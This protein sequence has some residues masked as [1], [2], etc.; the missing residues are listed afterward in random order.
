MVVQRLRRVPPR[1]WRLRLKGPK[2]VA[3]PGALLRAGV[4]LEQ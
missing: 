3:S 4:G 2:A 1:P